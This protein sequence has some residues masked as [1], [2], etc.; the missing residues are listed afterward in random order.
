MKWKV[1]KTRKYSN[2]VEHLLILA[3]TIT[4][5]VSISAFASLVHVPVGNRSSAIEIKVCAITAGIKKYKSIIKK[6]KKKHDKIVLLGKDKLNTIEVLISK[7]LTDSYISHD[8][9]LSINNVLRGYN[10]M[11]KIPWN[12]C[13]IQ[14][15]KMVDISSK[16][17]KRNAIEISVDNDGILWLNEKHTEEGLDHKNLREIAKKYNS[18]HRKHWYEVVE[19]PK[20]QV[21]TI[22]INEKLAV[23]VIMDCRTTS[24]HKFRARLGFKQYDVI[25]TKGQTVLKK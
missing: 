13:E 3:S 5:C 10:E 25:L 24:A 14:C 23:K 8:E 2:Y 22:F 12:F 1:Q 4:G 21:I 20:K 9:R 16:T 18:Y 15:I 6:K 11:K 19:E 7:A 17:Y